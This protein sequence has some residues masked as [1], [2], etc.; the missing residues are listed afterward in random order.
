MQRKPVKNLT[1]QDKGY[2]IAWTTEL[3][4]DYPCQVYPRVSTPE[5]R[6][7]MSAEMQKDKSFAIKCGW[8]DDGGN[9]ILDTSDL[10][11]SGQ[12]R[13]E[14]RVAFNAMLRRISNHEIKA[15][16]ASNVDRLF[17]NKWGDEPGKFMQ[18]CHDNGVVVITP[19]FVY[20][21][22]ISWH[23]DRFKRRCEEAWSYL[24]YHIYG[25]MLKAQDE[26]GFAG[27]WT[28]GNLP[29]GYIVDNKKEING[30]KVYR[31]IFPYEP[32]ARIVKKLFKRFGE[33]RGHLKELFREVHAGKFDFPDFDEGISKEVIARY[34][35]KKIP[36]GYRMSDESALAY[37]LTNRVYIGHWIYKGTLISEDNHPAIV[38]LDLFLYAYT[39][40]SPL[41]L[42]G[43]PNQIVLERRADRVKRH[44]QAEQPALLKDCITASDPHYEVYARVVDTHTRG[45]VYYY[46]FYRKHETIND[47]AQYMI[48]ASPVDKLV[49]KKVVEC[50][51]TAE[52]F[53]D[54]L[55]FEGEEIKEQR[56]ALKDIERDIHAV[57]TLIAQ[58]KIQLESGTLAPYPEALAV[59]AESYQRHKQDLE[60]L[61]TRKNTAVQAI[62]KGDKRRSIQQLMKE[63]GDRWEEVVLPEEYP[64]MIDLFIKKVILDNVSP[65][66]FK[67]EIQWLNPNWGVSEAVC[68]RDG[69]PSKRW[70]P[71]EDELLRIHYPTATKLELLQML[72]THTFRSMVT[73]ANRVLGI[74]RLVRINEGDIPQWTCW[75][76]WQLM[77]QY[78]VTEDD[79]HTKEGVKLVEWAR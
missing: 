56:Q 14:D 69:S 71:E 61:H 6:K 9:I 47:H 68:Y 24:E 37:L 45:D 41:N 21:F 77:Q 39:Q 13:M 27:Y 38:P 65:K 50:L 26:L 2:T 22:R 74:E 30:R 52:E 32:H 11:V 29:I 33:L 72:P 5:Q 17:R 76:D 7:N 23:V 16:I 19:D 44:Y 42:D 31:K 62:A 25:R 46:G 4:T 20:D 43:T 60:R 15:V 79:M 78:H 63:V 40:L 67:F 1:E 75:D 51:Q 55:S 58:L 36:G 34:H 3:P 35:L 10:G 18:I 54:Y 49:L 12:L 64:E 70:T 73:H 8:V 57:K 28:K 66:F 53:E 59:T 48:P